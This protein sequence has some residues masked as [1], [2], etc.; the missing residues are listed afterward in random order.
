MQVVY[1]SG[2]YRAPTL[3][4]ILDNIRLAEKVAIEYWK[5]GYAVICPHKNTALFDG[6]CADDIWLD[7][8]LEIISRCDIVVMLPF[9]EYSKG[10]VVEHGHAVNLGKEIVYHVD[11]R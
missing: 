7:G 5:K 8:D 1:I 3:Q 11:P 6:E 9:W 4:G 10:A 2:A